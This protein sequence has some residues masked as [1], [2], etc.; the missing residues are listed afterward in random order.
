MPMR[1]SWV[2][3]FTQKRESIYCY[4]DQDTEDGESSI[5]MARIC[6][7]ERFKIPRNLIP[8]FRVE[9]AD[10]RPPPVVSESRQSAR[11]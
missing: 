11:S 3:P 1:I 2:N 8:G 10:W 7:S 4:F 6:L 9:A 5:R